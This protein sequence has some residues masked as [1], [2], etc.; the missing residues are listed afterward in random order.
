MLN[1]PP[2][3]VSVNV[4]VCVPEELPSLMSSSDG[5][6]CADSARTSGPLGLRPVSEHAAKPTIVEA[7]TNRKYERIESMGSVQWR[8]QPTMTRE[9]D[10][11]ILRGGY[12]APQLDTPL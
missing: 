5:P 3:A 2:A 4:L 12:L 7:T 11:K 10:S 1:V 9:A 6:L 8:S